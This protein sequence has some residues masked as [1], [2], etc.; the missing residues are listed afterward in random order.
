MNKKVISGLKKILSQFDDAKK[1][2]TSSY[3]PQL[4]S[5]A[6]AECARKAIEFTIAEDAKKNEK[7]VVEKVYEEGELAL[8]KGMKVGQIISQLGELLDDSNA[9]DISGGGI[10]FKA[11]N[12]KFYTIT[13]EAL[14][15]EANPDFVKEALE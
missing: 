11:T 8:E 3:A 13:V 10:L 5:A 14:I 4:L 6:Q 1:A 9:S 2:G 15:S 12:G 7:I